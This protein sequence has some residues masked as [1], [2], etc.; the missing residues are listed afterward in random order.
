[1]G[2]PESSTGLASR[3]K[4]NRP[5]GGRAGSR[6]ITASGQHQGILFDG[7]TASLTPITTRPPEPPAAPRCAICGTDRNVYIV[8]P[9]YLCHIHVALAADVFDAVGA[10]CLRYE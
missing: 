8:E 10:D 3:G 9:R 4:R 7:I 2:K 5:A 6:R 1:M